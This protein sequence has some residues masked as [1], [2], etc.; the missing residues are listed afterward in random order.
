M[1]IWEQ[2]INLEEK[3]KKKVEMAICIPYVG[4]VTMQW[5]ITM[6][7]LLLPSHTY[8]FSKGTPIDVARETMVR[9]ALN[10][11]VDYIMFIDSDNI[12][13]H[14]DAVLTLKEIAEKRNLDIVSGLYWAKKADQNV[15]AAWK[16][17]SDYKYLPIVIEE[18][19]LK[20]GAILEVDVIGLGF[21]L[22][23]RRVFDMLE[24]KNPG[25]PFF[26]WGMGRKGE[27]E[28]SEDFYFCE[29]VIQELN[30]HPYVACSVP[31]KHACI[32]VKDGKTGEFELGW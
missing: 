28:I 10:L 18:D 11:D 15:P 20:S 21:C 8:F 7:E 23:K 5:A 2:Q 16:R 4:N 3:E 24:E 6:K 13:E 25:K 17:V 27:I 1:A 31:V 30:I 29:R 32:A 12:P 22:I 9:G 26:K 19:W 14:R